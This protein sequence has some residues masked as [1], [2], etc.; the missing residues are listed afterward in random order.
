MAMFGRESEQEKHKAEEWTAWARARNPLALASFVLGLFSLIELGAIPIFSLA[1]LILAI[2]ALRQ[3]RSPG[4]KQQHGHRL[5][6]AGLVL[7]GAALI[8]GSSLYIHSM[9]SR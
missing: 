1:G 2:V 8:I 3:L 9:M 4:A 7:S 6:W 5:A